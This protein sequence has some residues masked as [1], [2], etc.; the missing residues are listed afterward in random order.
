[1][2]NH[3]PLYLK[4][5]AFVGRFDGGSL[6]LKDIVYEAD[7]APTDT[8]P[9]Y[10]DYVVVGDGGEKTSKYNKLSKAIEDGYIFAL[11]TDELRS[12]VEGIIPA[13]ERKQNPNIVVIESR[14]ARENREKTGE[15]VW[16][17]KRESFIARYGAPG[18]EGTRIKM[19]PM[20][21]RAAV[22]AVRE[23]GSL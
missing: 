19:N 20:A 3:K 13:P 9:Y 17:D 12:I 5:V 1:M 6:P 23:L 11:T 18:P 10:T 16:Q 8:L 14:E 21:I 22:R 2:S 4:F 15:L 7:G